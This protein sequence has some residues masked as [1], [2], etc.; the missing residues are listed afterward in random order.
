MAFE[1]EKIWYGFDLTH[2]LKDA[3]KIVK[4]ISNPKTCQSF[5]EKTLQLEKY[6]IWIPNTGIRQY[7]DINYLNE[8]GLNLLLSNYQ[9]EKMRDCYISINKYYE[10]DTLTVDQAVELINSEIKRFKYIFDL[11]RK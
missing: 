6:F 8:K 9:P 10:E 1:K 3:Q 11:V 2:A 7:I 5:I 4:A